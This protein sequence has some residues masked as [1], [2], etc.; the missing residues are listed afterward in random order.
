MRATGISVAGIGGEGVAARAINPAGVIDLPA[1]GHQSANDSILGCNIVAQLEPR[2]RIQDHR[3]SKGTAAHGGE[4]DNESS[5]ARVATV[6]EGQ[7]TRSEP[8]Q[9]VTIIHIPGPGN[10]RRAAERG[11]GGHFHGVVERC[12]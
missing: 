8:Q 1:A 5:A 4:H 12:R 3:A 9:V 7:R 2:S 10:G 6:V 11:T